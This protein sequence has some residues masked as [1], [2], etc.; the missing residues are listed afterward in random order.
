[1]GPVYQ[2]AKVPKFLINIMFQLCSFPADE[3]L[4]LSNGKCRFGF[5]GVFVGIQVHMNHHEKDNPPGMKPSGQASLKKFIS[6]SV[7]TKCEQSK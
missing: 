7:E 4:A 2:R 6:G 1:M 5:I 3:R